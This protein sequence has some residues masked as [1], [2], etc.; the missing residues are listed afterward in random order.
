MND[1]LFQS[2]YE[3]I[4]QRDTRYDGRY[5]IGITSTGIF[6]RPSCRSRIPKPENVKIYGSIE[7]ALQAGFRACKRC[8]PEQPGE[9]GPDAQI[10]H[11]VNELIKRRY[12]EPLTLG[13]IGAELKMSPYHLQR[14]FKR[15]TGTTPSKQLLHIRME[16]A[17]RL[18]AA[19]EQPI[20]D[21][22]AEVGFRSPSHFTSV[23]HKTVGCTPME[24][25]ETAGTR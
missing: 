1:A 13:D 6:C 19:S 15:V 2:V 16:E 20:T 9:H 7:E 17:Q 12:S 5:Y 22:A 21:I 25:R 3:T 24:Y 10:A 18:L 8:R 23:F 11:A 4:L 14:V